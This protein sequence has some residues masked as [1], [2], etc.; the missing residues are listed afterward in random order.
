MQIVSGNLHFFLQIWN[1]K[2]NFGS[3]SSLSLYGKV[4]RADFSLLKGKNF[5]PV[6]K[7][8]IVVNGVKLVGKI[9]KAKR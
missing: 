4:R 7:I 1:R 6:G 9:W 8:K 3:F 2:W 5:S